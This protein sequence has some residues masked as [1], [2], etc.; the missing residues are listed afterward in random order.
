MKLSKQKELLYFGSVECYFDSVPGE[1]FAFSE[2]TFI[3][4]SDEKLKKKSLERNNLPEY[5]GPEYMSLILPAVPGTDPIINKLEKDVSSFPIQL[6]KPI[7]K[8]RDGN[9]LGYHSGIRSAIIPFNGKYYRLKGCGN[10]YEKF[11]LFQIPHEERDDLVEIRGCTFEH[12]S[13]RELLYFGKVNK[14]MMENDIPLSNISLGWYEYNLSKTPLPKVKRVCAIYETKGEKRLADHLLTGIERLLPLLISTEKFDSKDF[15]S[16]YP[17][18]R[19]DGDSVI[20][21]WMSVSCEFDLQTSYF[22]MLNFDLPEISPKFETKYET[23]KDIWEENSSILTLGLE[24]LKKNQKSAKSLL[25]YLYWRLGREVGF[26]QKL[27]SKNNINW[28]TYNDK[29]GDHSNS[30]ANNLVILPMEKVDRN[31]LAPLDFDMAYNKEFFD[32]SDD[33]LFQDW[34]K[35]EEK[36]QACSISGAD[37]NSGV[38]EVEKLDN[39]ILDSIRWGLRDTMLLGYYNALNDEKDLCPLDPKLT[40]YCYALIELALI[41]TSQVIA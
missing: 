9:I 31:F 19:V 25:S 32:R 1:T 2:E 5:K 36:A 11:P 21:T 4:S 17:S 24:F 33:K 18:V 37:F 7:M 22:N 8:S 16:K 29:L 15:L 6:Q 20:S 38:R 26:I 41:T 27:F 3:E 40:E 28:G 12:T 30:H 35:M 23:W 39:P 34:L 14:L 10:M 13:S